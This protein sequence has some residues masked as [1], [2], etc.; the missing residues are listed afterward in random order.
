[1]TR[2]RAQ[3]LAFGAFICVAMTLPL[4]PTLGMPLQRSLTLDVA[5]TIVSVSLIFRIHALRKHLWMT[6]WIAVPTAASLLLAAAHWWRGEPTNSALVGAVGWRVVAGLMTICLIPLN[7][8]ARIRLWSAH[9]TLVLGLCAVSGGIV[10]GISEL[11]AARGEI[12]ALLTVSDWQ[13]SIPRIAL[14]V[15]L[16]ALLPVMSTH[17]AFAVLG[18]LATHTVLEQQLPSWTPVSIGA[19]GATAHWFGLRDHTAFT[20]VALAAVVNWSIAAVHSLIIFALL[21]N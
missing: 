3:Q 19:L 7:P 5:M 15:A 20:G 16:L 14:A 11:S 6:C 10:F 17:G 8:F 9:P 1:M 4:S 13:L 21:V 2:Q 18:C 12:A